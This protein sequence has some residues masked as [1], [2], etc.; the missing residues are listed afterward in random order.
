MKVT[1]IYRPVSEHARDVE[2]YLRDFSKQTGRSLDTLDPDTTEGSE[3]CRV[4]DIVEYPTVIA[5]SDD[6]QLQNSWRGLPL[7]TISEV[8]YYA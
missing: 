8:S 5:V 4:Y 2:E 3:T 1:I 6:G 7:P